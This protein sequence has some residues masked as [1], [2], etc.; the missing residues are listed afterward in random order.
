MGRCVTPMVAAI[1]V[2]SYALIG[3][4]DVF[5]GVPTAT[6]VLAP[7]AMGIPVLAALGRLTQMPKPL[8]FPEPES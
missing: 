4:P 1:P 6:R 2:I 8:A 3:L 5:I 7:F